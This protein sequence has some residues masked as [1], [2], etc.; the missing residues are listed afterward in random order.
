MTTKQ[1]SRCNKI[2]PLSFF[3]KRNTSPD[4]YRGMCRTCTNSDGRDRWNRN[5]EKYLD[6]RRKRQERTRDSINRHNRNYYQHHRLACLERTKARYR[7]ERKDIL[8][9]QQMRRVA[10]PEQHL[11]HLA[12]RRAMRAGTLTAPKVC[13][14][15]G[16]TRVVESH[17]EDY[18]KVLDVH[19]FCSS[20]HKRLHSGVWT[21]PKETPHA[22]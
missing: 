2:L 17:H 15:C 7:R 18:R 11:A 4:G 19:W 20:C 6:V 5:R 8:A 3:L 16:L 1:C 14:H 22:P 9:R 12:I 10:Y 13:E 21:M